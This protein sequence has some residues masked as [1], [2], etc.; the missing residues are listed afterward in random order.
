MVSSLLHPVAAGKTAQQQE[1]SQS[2]QRS[3]LCQITKQTWGMGEKGREEGS[4][5]LVY[6]QV[7]MLLHLLPKFE[8]LDLEESERSEN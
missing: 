4:S 6:S 8:F 7:K 3:S 2:K 1:T 5:P